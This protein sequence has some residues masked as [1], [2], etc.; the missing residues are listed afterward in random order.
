MMKTI[1]IGDSWENVMAARVA[2]LFQFVRFMLTRTIYEYRLAFE[3]E[4]TVKN[5]YF[6]EKF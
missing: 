3:S 4:V 6:R 2:A 5:I 1:L